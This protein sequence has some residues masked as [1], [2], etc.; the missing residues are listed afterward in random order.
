[1]DVPLSV[2]LKITDMAHDFCRSFCRANKA[3]CPSTA[4]VAQRPTSVGDSPLR[5][6][7]F[8]AQ[9]RSSVSAG[10][11]GPHCISSLAFMVCVEKARLDV[12][13]LSLSLFSFFTRPHDH[14][15]SSS[16]CASPL[17]LSL[18]WLLHQLWLCR[19]PS[20]TLSIPAQAPS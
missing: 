2:P 14:F 17:L 5:A 19:L 4:D 9:A 11:Q 6:K 15:Q 13:F 1:M 20:S 12:R 10:R 7:Y 8:N 16:T 3:V 18:S